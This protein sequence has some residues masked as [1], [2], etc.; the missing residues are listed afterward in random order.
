MCSKTERVRLFFDQPA[1]YLNRR[2]HDIRLRAEVV[3]HLAGPIRN[4]TILDIGCGDGSLSLPLLDNNNRLTLLDISPQMLSLA[5]SR[6]ATDRVASVH[7]LNQDF[8]AACFLP[9]SFDLVICVGVL[10]HVNSP[11][12]FLA[13]IA[14]ILKPNGVLIL[15][16]TDS[17]HFVGRAITLYHRLCNALKPFQYSLNLLR[18]SEV[19]SVAGQHR[20]RLTGAFRY[21]LLPPGTHRLLSQDSMYNLTRAVFGTAA[22][23]RNRWMGNEYICKFIFANG[24]SVTCLPDAN[25]ETSLRHK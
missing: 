6:I 2:R 13:K 23:N 10:A 7:L 3:Q 1:N 22:R 18:S 12:E 14:S 25:A 15:E 20:F 24:P 11:E 9:Q 5:R 16:Y 4:Q 8:M 19:Q 21:S 17:Y